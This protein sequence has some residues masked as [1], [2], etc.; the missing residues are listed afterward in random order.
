MYTPV[1]RV[2]LGTVPR[3]R[4][5]VDLTQRAPLLVGLYVRGLALAGRRE[6][7]LAAR[8][9]LVTQAQREYVG[10]A[11]MLMTIALDVDDEAAAVAVIQANVDAMTG[12]VTIATT[13]V[14]ELM[15]L[16]DHPRLGPLIR[17]LTL[18]S[19]RAEAV[20]AEP[21]G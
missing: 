21:R 20:A 4:R 3:L 14:R 10:P 5:A 2:R 16:L 11:A 6:E 19:A 13:V 8:A 9:E 18:W 17:R 12:P 7:A 15:P 1:A